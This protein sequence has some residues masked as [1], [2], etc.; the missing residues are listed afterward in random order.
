MRPAYFHIT[1]TPARMRSASV[2]VNAQSRHNSEN[3]HKTAVNEKA[4]NTDSKIK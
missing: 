4:S 2:K 1:R 3:N